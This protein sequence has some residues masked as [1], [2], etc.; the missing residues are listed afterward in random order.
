MTPRDVTLFA[1]T[2]RALQAAWSDAQARNDVDAMDRINQQLGRDPFN[3]TEV[4][5]EA[6]RPPSV[7]AAQP[8]SLTV[9]DR[10]RGRG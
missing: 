8:E 4:V 2:R 10:V 6:A 9:L 3:R 1:N 7:R 5:A